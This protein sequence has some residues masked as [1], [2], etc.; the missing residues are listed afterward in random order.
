MMGFFIIPFLFSW[1]VFEILGFSI[2]GGFNHS[3]A[4][5]LLRI[6]FLIAGLVFL[7]F[8]TLWQKTLPLIYDLQEVKNALVGGNKKAEIK[9]KEESFA[10]KINKTFFKKK[11]F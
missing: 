10:N 9:D 1:L 4:F 5:A 3:L 8:F 6:I 7:F 2:N 11:S